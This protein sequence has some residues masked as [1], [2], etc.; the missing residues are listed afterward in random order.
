MRNTIELEPFQ[1]KGEVIKI[2][3]PN[4]ASQQI[5]QHWNNFWKH[6]NFKELKSMPKAIYFNYEG[7]QN[8]P[9]SFLVGLSSEENTELENEETLNKVE[10]KNEVSHTITIPKQKYVI[11]E[12]TGEMPQVVFEAWQEVWNSNINRSFNFDIEEYPNPNT[13]KLYIGLNE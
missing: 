3:N 4:E 5:M 9:Y 6:H 8:D 11:I 10:N 2:N 12:K 7:N 1:I 13:V